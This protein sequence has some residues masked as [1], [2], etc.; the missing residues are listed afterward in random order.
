M[1]END[2]IVDQFK[3]SLSATIKSIG[4][5]NTIEVNFVQ[6]GP[7]I[8]GDI[9]NL[10]EPNLQSLK[11]NLNYIRAEADLMALEIRLHTKEIHQEYLGNNDVVNEIFNAVEQSRIEAQG[12][13][14]FKG[15]KLNILNKHKFDIQNTEDKNNKDKEDYKEIIEAFR[16]VSY[17]E[18]TGEILG[19]KFS[20]YKK[21]IQKKLGHGYNDFFKKLRNNITNQ[22]NFADL[23]QTFLDNLGYYDH[24]NK[25]D[26]IDN[27]D[28]SEDKNLHDEDNKSKIGIGLRL[29][30]RQ[31]DGFKQ[32]QP[33]LHPGGRIEI[34]LPFGKGFMLYLETANCGVGKAAKSDYLHEIRPGGLSCESLHYGGPARSLQAVPGYG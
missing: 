2:E 18:L 4:K 33:L 17:S 3:K 30:R 32:A 7:S 20:A 10:N 9:I 27:E 22:K 34:G 31:G 25:Q 13:H 8:D 15:I 5:S 6:D 28:R 23:L 1:L 11:K 21:L 16:Y 12:S 14:I 24:N 29:E 19:G 26:G